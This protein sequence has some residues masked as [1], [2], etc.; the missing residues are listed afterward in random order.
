MHVTVDDDTSTV[1]QS[2]AWGPTGAPSWATVDDGAGSVLQVVHTDQVWNPTVHTDATG[3][4]TH[5]VLHDAWGANGTV[6]TVNAAAPA[7]AIGHSSSIDAASAGGLVHMRARDYDPATG[8]FLTPDP[9]IRPDGTPWVGVHAYTD[10]NPVSFWDPSGLRECRGFAAFC[11]LGRLIG[12]GPRSPDPADTCAGWDIYCDPVRLAGAGVIVVCVAATTGYCL[13]ATIGYFGVESL[14]DLHG[15][16]WTL[17][18]NFAKRRF[19]SAASGAA[20]LG[21]G[22]AASSVTGKTLAAGADA[23]MLGANPCGRL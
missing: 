15:N 19:C 7:P 17:D 18:S 2:F 3:A 20:S 5:T 23:V 16:G 13:A 6:T 21:L 9:W 10:G 11:A 22:G 12:M 8:Q 1:E 14:D 4:V